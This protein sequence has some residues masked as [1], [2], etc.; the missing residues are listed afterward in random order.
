MT[1][2]FAGKSGAMQKSFAERHVLPYALIAVRA[3]ANEVAARSTGASDG[4]IDA[5]LE[6]LWNGTNNLATTSKMGH[7]SLLLLD[8]A[9]ASGTTIGKLDDRLTLVSD[10]EDTALRSTRDYQLDVGALVSALVAD[11]G[12]IAKVRIQQDGRLRTFSDGNAG[13]VEE[14]LEKAGVAAETLG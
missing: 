7:A 11:K 4:D 1:A 8:V 6:A 5:M 12:R 13:T 9:F 10:K 14:H 2:A 3:V